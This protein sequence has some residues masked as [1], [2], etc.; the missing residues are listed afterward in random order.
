MQ[1]LNS[2]LASTRLEKDL[3]FTLCLAHCNIVSNLKVRNSVGETKEGQFGLSALL[4]EFGYLE[5]PAHDHLDHGLGEL[6]KV[7]VVKHL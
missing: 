6:Q 1:H 5:V 4:G 7:L 3:F 2:I